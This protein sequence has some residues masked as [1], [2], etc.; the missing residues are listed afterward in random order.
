MATLV[1]GLR[2]G[3]LV[4]WL[5]QRRPWRCEAAIGIVSSPNQQW[6]TLSVFRRI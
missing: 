6:R 5:D 1:A 4:V 2:S 3:A